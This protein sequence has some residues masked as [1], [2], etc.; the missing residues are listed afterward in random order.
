MSQPTVSVETRGSV[1]IVTI[2]RPDSSNTLNVQVGMD[3][4]AAA[5]TCGRNSAVRA[6]V[7][8][9]AGKHFCFGGDLRS[10]QAKGA[11]VEAYIRELTGYLHAAISQFV[12][13][14][15]PVIA[16]VN[17]TAAGGGVGFVAMADLAIAAE[18]AKFNLAYTAAGLV[19]DCST[20][21]FLPRILGTKRTLELMLTNRTLTAKE[22][23][24]W[25]LVNEVVPDKDVLPEALKVAERLA[26]G[27]LRSFG[28]TKRLLAQSLPGLESQMVFES[29][30]ISQQAATAEGQ[31]GIAAFLEKRKPRF[32]RT[33]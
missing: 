22:A 13:M 6:V 4:L 25:G 7:L 8:T 3:L 14:D 27:A 1:A 21:F 20:T 31:E 30:G 23:L 18:S 26:G 28:K 9:G 29:E 10:M 2:D 11:G 24:E 19:P 12:R 5:I 32:S 16:A 33:S 15:A 17:G